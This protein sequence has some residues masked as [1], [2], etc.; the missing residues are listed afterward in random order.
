MARV[1]GAGFKLARV[2]V[3]LAPIASARFYP[4]T[5]GSETRPTPITCLGDTFLGQGWVRAAKNPSLVKAQRECLR[6][7]T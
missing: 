6:H 3:R 1:V 2:P 5:G 4:A 7:R